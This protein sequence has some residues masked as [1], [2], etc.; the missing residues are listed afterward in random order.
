MGLPRHVPKQRGKPMHLLGGIPSTIY[1]WYPQS[2]QRAN[3]SRTSILATMNTYNHNNRMSCSVV[4]WVLTNNL[5]VLVWWALT[6]QPRLSKPLWPAPKSKHSDKQKVWIFDVWLTKPTPISYSVYH[7]L[8]KHFNV[9]S[10]FWLRI[11]AHLR[12][13]WPSWRLF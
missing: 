4:W 5:S 6:V 8:T 2:M 12:F 13:T 9:S 1:W 7:R 11:I 3:K 10:H